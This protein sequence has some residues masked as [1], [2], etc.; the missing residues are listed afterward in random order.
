MLH[1]QSVFSGFTVDDLDVAEKFYTEKLGITVE[2]LK[3]GNGEDMGLEL[4][5]PEG[6]RVFVYAKNDHQPASYT[7]LNF[8]VSDIDT[9]V[10]QLNEAGITLKTYEGMHQDEKG[11]A[12]GLDYD[13]GPSIAWFKDPAGNTLAVL[14]E[15]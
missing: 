3:M 7:V 1:I 15:K 2:R 14:Q 5:M 11:I 6:M 13:M 10:A 8:Q 4:Q 12:R 9:A